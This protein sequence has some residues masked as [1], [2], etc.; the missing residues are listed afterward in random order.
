MKS[1]YKE[2]FEIPKCVACGSEHLCYP[3]MIIYGQ[4]G[5]KHKVIP[6]EIIGFVSGAQKGPPPLDTPLK[7]FVLL[8]GLPGSEQ[9]IGQHPIDLN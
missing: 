8:L 9:P 6:F 5:N 2:Q 7:V 3:D 1:W 4:D